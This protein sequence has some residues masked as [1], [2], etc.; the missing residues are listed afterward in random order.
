[1][2]ATAPALSRKPTAL[3]GLDPS[4]FRHPLDR[5]ATDQLK[6]LRGFDKLVAKFIE[7][8]VERIDYVRNI[9][10]AVR[11]GPRQM[12]QLYEMLLECCR[13]LD[14]PEP[15][16]YIGQ[17]HVNAFTSGHNHP[18]I[19]VMT[20][21][22]E[23]MDDDEVM[24]VIAHEV[25]HIKCGHVL[26]KQMARGITPFLEMIGKATLGLGSLLGMGIEAA[27]LS[28]DRRSELSADRASLLVTQDARP[29]VSMLMKLAGGTGRYAVQLDAEQFLHQARTYVE[30]LDES[31]LDRFYRFI[32]GA[33]GSHPFP[34]ER[35]R[36]LDEWIESQEYKQII[37]GDYL[38]IKL[39]VKARACPTCGQPAEPT[40]KFCTQCGTPL[41][42][43]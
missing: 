3:M 28:W 18:H 5:Q 27:L 33:G 1:M 13:I 17:G 15:E 26:Y 22:L 31:V 7:Y 36:A 29:C 12:P 34:V 16:L 42:T 14:V 40:R 35:A 25:G 4:A 8:G 43:H 9:G 39:G 6:K 11:V 32:A 21:L 37:A 41:V 19:M 20:G 24:A 38:R 23:L 10:G 30:G 2:T